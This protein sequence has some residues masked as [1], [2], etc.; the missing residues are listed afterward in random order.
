MQFDSSSR[1][2]GERINRTLTNV[3][4]LLTPGF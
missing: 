2:A 3:W 1:R 4:G